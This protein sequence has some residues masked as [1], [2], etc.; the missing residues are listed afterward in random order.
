MMLS[1]LPKFQHEVEENKAELIFVIDRS[2]SM[3][4]DGIHLAKKS[5]LV[6]TF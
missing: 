6:N 4:G 1:I 2:N 3:N 5:I